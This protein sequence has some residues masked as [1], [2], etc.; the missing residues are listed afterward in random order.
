VAVSA[1]SNSMS[2]RLGGVA[3]WGFRSMRVASS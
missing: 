2:E 1:A 3:V